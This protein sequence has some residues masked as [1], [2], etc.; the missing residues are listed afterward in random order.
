MFELFGKLIKRQQN[1]KNGGAGRVRTSCAGVYHQEE[2]KHI[3]ECEH[4]SMHC[5][6][7]GI[8]ISDFVITEQ[9]EARGKTH[10]CRRMYNT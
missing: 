9:R 2:A 1:Q 5:G 6:G 3:W 8:E 7:W 10:R 4:S